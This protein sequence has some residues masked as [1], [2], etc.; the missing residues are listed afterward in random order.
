MV[1]KGDVLPY[2]STFSRV[3]SIEAG[4]AIGVFVGIVL[5]LAGALAL[6][7]RRASKDREPSHKHEWTLL[8]GS[9]VVALVGVAIFLTWLS[10]SANADEVQT[11]GRPALVVRVVAYQ[12]CWRFDYIGQHAA[13]AGT[14]LQGTDYPTLMLPTDRSIELQVES[15]DVVHEF[16]VPHLDYKIEAF[17]NYVNSFRLRLTSDGRWIGRCAEFCGLYHTYMH[18][19]LQ[20]E[21]PAAFQ[22]WLGSHHAAVS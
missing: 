17:P 20:A 12:W 22:R 3:F 11:S 19:F 7:H 8:E 16:W 10:L 9:W 2:R 14:C 18:F 5:L 4:I 15:N 21:S 1:P 6:G 13:S